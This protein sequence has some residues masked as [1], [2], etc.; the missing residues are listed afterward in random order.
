VLE[1]RSD[2]HRVT[3]TLIEADPRNAARATDHVNRLHLSTVEVRCTDAGVSGAYLGA[4]P[5]DLVLLCGIFGNIT[6]DDVRRTIAA[7]P[8]LCN[9]GA[10]VVWTRHRR[11]PDLTPRIR[12]WFR[13]HG[14]AE[15][16]FEAP[17]HAM[18]SVGV[19]RFIGSPSPPGCWASPVHLRPVA[20]TATQRHHARAH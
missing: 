19:H 15:E 16:H 9:E 4:V 17:D 13:E 11:E 20:A 10:V 8:Q 6:D 1:R 18:Y 7:T 5:A 14:F 2:A 3:A 12:E